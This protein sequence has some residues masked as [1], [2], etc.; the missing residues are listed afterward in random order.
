LQN[1]LTADAGEF[2]FRN[3][4]RFNAPFFISADDRLQHRIVSDGL[5]D[6]ADQCPLFDQTQRSA[7]A[8]LAHGSTRERH[9]VLDRFRRLNVGRKARRRIFPLLSTESGFGKTHP[10]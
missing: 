9:D 10:E 8:G 4:A 1:L 5:S 3:D 7:A 6:E 2:I